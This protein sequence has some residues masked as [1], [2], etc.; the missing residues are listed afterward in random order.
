MSQGRTYCFN[1]LRISAIGL[2]FGGMVHAYM[3]QIAI[4]NGRARPI[5]L[6][7]HRTLKSPE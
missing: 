5:F 4:S 2:E 1:S 3:K 6:A 7:F